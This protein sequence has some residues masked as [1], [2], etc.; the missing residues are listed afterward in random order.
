MKTYQHSMLGPEG[1]GKSRP[2]KAEAPTGPLDWPGWLT[3]QSSLPLGLN[4]EPPYCRANIT[5][6]E[7][8]L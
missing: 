3:G 1:C 4:Q 6:S 8:C 5:S 2:C 7:I